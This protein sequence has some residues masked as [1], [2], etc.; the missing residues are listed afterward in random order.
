MVTSREGIVYGL[1]ERE[2]H[3]P[4]DELSSTGAKLIL[5]SPR[6]FKYQV[7]DGHRVHRPAF[8][9][10]TVVHTKVLG[11]GP[12]FAE[13]PEEHLTATG[14]ASTK[15]ATVQWESEQRAAGNVLLTPAQAAQ[16]ADMAESVLREPESRKLFEREGNPEVSIFHELNGVKRRGRFDYMPT[17]GGFVV[18]LKTTLDASYYGFRSSVERYG[19]HI[20]YGHYIDILERITGEKRD[21]IFV[22]VEKDPPY[23]VNVIRFDETEDYARIG[24]AEALQAVDDYRRCVETGEWPGLLRNG[25]TKIKPSMGLLYDFHDK[26]ESEEMQI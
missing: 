5:K 19:Y 13:Y 4:K 22:A 10:G 15:A 26:Y 12:S 8:D 17:E 16:A 18:D 6:K 7:L 23:E 25:I 24:E 21:M 3:A 11:A 14:N 9:L 20:Q 2:Y 1:P